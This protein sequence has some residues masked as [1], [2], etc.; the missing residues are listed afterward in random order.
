MAKTKNP[1]RTNG[2]QEKGGQ[3]V[4]SAP[5]TPSPITNPIVATAAPA[6]ENRTLEAPKPASRKARKPELVKTESRSNLLPINMDDEI[7]NLAYLLSER[8]GFE[9]GHETEDW[10]AAEHEVLARYHQQHSA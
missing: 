3:E 6:A 7:R 5:T 4:V 1:K 9:P 10:L 2:M 8:R